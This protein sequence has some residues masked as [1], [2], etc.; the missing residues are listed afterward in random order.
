LLK[1]PD[2]LILITIWEFLTVL[3]VVVG[4]VFMGIYAYPIAI[5][6]LWGVARVGMLFGLS[7][8]TLILLLYCGTGLLGGIGL[9]TGK[10]WGRMLSIVHSVLSL[11]LVPIGT[12]IGTLAI[13]YLTK[14]E[15]KEYFETYGK[16]QEIA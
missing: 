16:T 1:K 15:V 4:L 2:L 8:G 5:E 11:I 6:L 12:I 3:I 9:S 14:P 10:P 13:I 7:V